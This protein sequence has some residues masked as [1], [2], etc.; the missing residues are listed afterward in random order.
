MKRNLIKVLSIIAVGIMLF[1]ISSTSVLADNQEPYKKESIKNCIN[2]VERLSNNEEGKYKD[3]IEPI[4]KIGEKNE[5]SS[6]SISSKYTMADLN[7]VSFDELINIITSINWEQIE[8]IFEYNSDAYEFYSNEARFNAIVKA[9]EERGKTYTATDSKGIPTL[10]EVIR[11]GF[12]L[13]FYNEPLKI[14]NERK[15]QDKCLSAMVA[16]QANSNFKIGEPEQNEVI[17]SL[18]RLIGNG[19]ATSEII[20]NSTKIIKDFNDNLDSYC[21]DYYK[22]S[23]PYELMKGIEYE[24]TTYAYFNNVGIKDTPFY[25][26]IDSFINEVSR[27]ALKGNFTNDTEWAINCGIY[28]IGLQKK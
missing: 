11:A 1:N 26:K 24:V 16:I 15:T 19:S 2:N 12:Y 25:S 5:I 27:L 9:L 20:N 6:Y 18:G 17:G 21:A 14:L 3:T 28:Y 13:G 22:S 4:G 8:D 23:A 10:I 7:K